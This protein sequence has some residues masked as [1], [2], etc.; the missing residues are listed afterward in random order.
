MSAC[1]AVLVESACAESLLRKPGP[2]KETAT[3]RK[4]ASARVLIEFFI[5]FAPLE[6]ERVGS[7]CYKGG[8]IIYVTKLTFKSP[9]LIDRSVKKPLCELLRYFASFAFNVSLFLERIPCAKLAKYRKA[10]GVGWFLRRADPT[11]DSLHSSSAMT[12]IYA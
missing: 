8:P 4:T 2:A 7:V 11:S 6:S 3:S 9:N 5:V 1:A 10:R 12:R